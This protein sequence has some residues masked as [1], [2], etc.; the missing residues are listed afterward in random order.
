M[1]LSKLN[2][3]L[4]QN[5][6]GLR[7][8]WATL[9][10]IFVWFIYFFVNNRYLLSMNIFKKLGGKGKWMLLHELLQF[11]QFAVF[12]TIKTIKFKK[13]LMLKCLCHRRILLIK[14]NYRS[15]SIS[16]KNKHKPWILLKLYYYCAP[17]YKIVLISSFFHQCYC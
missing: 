8:R 17:S 16:I 15:G 14:K 1:Q 3:Q 10:Q 9:I 2:K 5:E 12:K 11:N 7:N 4:E 6:S 13:E